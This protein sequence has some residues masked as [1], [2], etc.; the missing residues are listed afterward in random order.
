MSKSKHKTLSA[1]V[2]DLEARGRLSFSRQEAIAALKSSPAAI[3][4]AYLRLKVK[5][6]ILSPRNGFFL[7]VPVRYRNSKMPPLAHWA[8]AL[9]EFHE[10]PYYLGL[11]S[12]AQFHG[13][14]HFFMEGDWLITDCSLRDITKEPFRIN[15]RYKE[16]SRL[17]KT[18]TTKLEVPTGQVV[19]ATAESTAFDLVRYLGRGISLNLCAT[20][21]LGMLQKAIVPELL[22]AAAKTEAWEMAVVQRTGYLLELVQEEHQIPGDKVRPLREWVSQLALSKVPLQPSSYERPTKVSEPWQVAVNAQVDVE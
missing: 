17:A 8:D 21:L 15:F 1:F 13:A 5:R 6:R 7:I 14:T 2:D 19:V 4:Q 20:A 22:L 12:S 9:M 16:S 10:R 3:K 11:F 18:P